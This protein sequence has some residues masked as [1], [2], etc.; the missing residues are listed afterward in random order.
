MQINNYLKTILITISMILWTIIKAAPATDSEK[1][2]TSTPTVA[3]SD[4]LKINYCPE[5]QKLTKNAMIWT[6]E[7]QW[8]SHSESFAEQISSFIGAQW[9]GVKIGTIICLYDSKDAFD[10]PIAL[11]P[12]HTMLV[13]EPQGDNWSVNVK[14]YR[15][16]HST[17]TQDCGFMIQQPKTAGSVYEQIEYHPTKADDK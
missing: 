12:I 13:L 15:I 6:V 10:F 5:I 11:E 16:C 14:G 2:V 7:N 9:V 8:R 4:L 3:N 17:S 1:S